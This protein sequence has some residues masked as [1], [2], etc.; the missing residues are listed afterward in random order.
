MDLEDCNCWG[1]A[2][3]GGP[4][5]PP[6]PQRVL[7]WQLAWR[8]PGGGA[9]AVI[10]HAP[11]VTNLLVSRAE[12]REQPAGAPSVIT[13]RNLSSADHGHRALRVG[14]DVLADRAEH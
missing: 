11:A 6:R 1:S 8:R 12:V 7:A 13:R 14:G 9:A 2:E 10:T 3:A 4:S 5:A